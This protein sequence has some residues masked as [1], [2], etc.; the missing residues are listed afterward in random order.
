MLHCSTW[1]SCIFC[2]MCVCFLNECTS[3]NASM[4][5]STTTRKT[6]VVTGTMSHL[7]SWE[8][9]SHFGRCKCNTA[10][11]NERI[12]A[13][14]KGSWGSWWKLWGVS[15]SHIKIALFRNIKPI[16]MYGEC[17]VPALASMFELITEACIKFVLEPVKSWYA[18][19]WTISLPSTYWCVSAFLSR[20][21]CFDIAFVWQEFEDHRNGAFAII[22]DIFFFPSAQ[23][24]H[25]KTGILFQYLSK[26]NRW[27]CFRPERKTTMKVFITLYTRNRYILC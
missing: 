25:K 14:S 24:K 12:S 22:S 17:H 23:K 18:I 13:T 7:T 21:N 27:G 9:I 5:A 6:A 19:T 8:S 11:H 15:N 4:L 20:K 26:K 1:T 16:Y 3:N 10:I 2:Q